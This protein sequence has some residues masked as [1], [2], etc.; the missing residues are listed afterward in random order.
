M[1][2]KW[3]KVFDSIKKVWKYTWDPQNINKEPKSKSKTKITNVP[4][5]VFQLKYLIGFV[6]LYMKSSLYVTSFLFSY[7]MLLF[8][9][10]FCLW[11]RKYLWFKLAWKVLFV[12]YNY[13]NFLKFLREIFVFLDAYWKHFFMGC[14]ENL[15]KLET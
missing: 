8:W 12:F 11:V 13:C 10:T 3:E 5:W 15:W 2:R 9:G 1:T 6:I 7:F 4:C 14:K